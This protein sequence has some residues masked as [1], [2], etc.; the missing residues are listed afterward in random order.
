MQCLAVEA[1]ATLNGTKT[2]SSVRW[3]ACGPKVHNQPALL[4]VQS[5]PVEWPGR[6]HSNRACWKLSQ[7][8]IESV[9]MTTF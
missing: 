3:S 8:Y 6:D 5:W 7:T 4:A 2:M 1:L 9:R